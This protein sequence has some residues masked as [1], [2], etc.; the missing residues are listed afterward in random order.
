MSATPDRW[1]SLEELFQAALNLPP[2]QRGAYLNEHCPDEQ[3]RQEVEALLGFA[4]QGDPILKDSPWGQSVSMPPGTELGP[5]RVSERIGSGGMGEVYKA[6]DT[7]LGRE[8][9]LKVLPEVLMSDPGR[10]ARFVSEAR[11]AS[12]LNHPNCVTVY[13][14]GEQDGRVFIAME[15]VEGKTLDAVIP[16]AGLPLGETLKYAI[17][18]A[19]AL[20]K[21]HAA[22][23]IHRDLKPGNIMVTADGT[24]KLLDF[25]LAKLQVRV[26]TEN[27]ATMQPH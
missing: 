26:P 19:A 14:I 16:R 13:D 21:A 1:R 12:R 11:T 9:A 5:Y 17:P 8:V 3:L 18:I 24:I 27:T 4:P 22:G 20:T 2:G 7:R 6:H 15:Y 10:R 23:I 25:G